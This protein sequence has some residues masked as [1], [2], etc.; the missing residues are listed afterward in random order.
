ME[1]TTKV[2]FKGN[3]VTGVRRVVSELVHAGTEPQ[4][5][6][7]PEHLGKLSADQIEAKYM[8]NRKYNQMLSD[9]RKDEIYAQIIEGR[10][11]LRNIAISTQ[12]RSANT[13]V[14]PVPAIAKAAIR[15]LEN[16][17]NF[18]D[19]IVNYTS[20]PYSQIQQMQLS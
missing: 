16:I 17:S 15:T 7:T 6:Y 14:R 19:R 13:T 12:H 18:V 10:K 20:T 2:T 8:T 11:Q 4:E 3:R 5:A 9:K 1:P